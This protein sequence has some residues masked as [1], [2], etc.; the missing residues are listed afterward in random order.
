MMS[1]AD[2]IADVALDLLALGALDAEELRPLQSHLAGCADCTRRMAEARGRMSLLAFAAPSEQPPAGARARLMERV[3]VSTAAIAKTP[4]QDFAAPRTAMAEFRAPR[5]A[6]WS[7]GWATLALG[8]AAAAL[9][10]WVN[11]TR[12]DRQLQSLQQSTAE[13]QQKQM[14]NQHLLE[15]FAAPDT[16]QVSLTPMPGHLGTP[17]GVQ[18]NQR[19][20][21]LVYAGA[22]P[23]LPSGRTYEL[24]LIPTAG[25]PI[26]AGVFH[27]DAAGRVTVMMPPLPVGV[28]PKAF[29]VTIEPEGGM[30]KPTGAMV[31]MGAVS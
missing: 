8:L 11:N 24:W 17:A 21:L 15:L 28:A 26:N 31:Q 9:L 16:I 23:P 30:P 6:T 20:G 4:A 5:K 13:L 27:P 12:L 19:R 29:A 14:Q 22:M 25:D 18:Y 7:L 10:L 3:R 2:H 1:N